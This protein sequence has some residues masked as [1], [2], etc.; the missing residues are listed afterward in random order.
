MHTLVSNGAIEKG[1]WETRGGG[2][3]EEKVVYFA[4][5]NFSKSDAF[6]LN[7]SI[8]NNVLLLSRSQ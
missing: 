3:G 4:K 1:G 2:G 8:D 5:F 6:P 7:V